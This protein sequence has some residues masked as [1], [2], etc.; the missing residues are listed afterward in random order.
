MGLTGALF[1]VKV[2]S[3][4][5]L[6]ALEPK[7][8]IDLLKQCC[9]STEWAT[10]VASKRPFKTEGQLLETAEAVWWGLRRE[11]W[12]EA[13]RAHPRLGETLASGRSQSA[14]WSSG[15]QSEVVRDGESR[16][17]LQRLNREYEA[18]FGWIF[19]L[20]ASGKSADDVRRSI[21]ERLKNDPASE[22]RVAAEEQNKITRL[23]IRKLLHADASVPGGSR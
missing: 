19:I 12:L 20:S 8:A 21:T 23:R 4:A 14:V 10:R 15:E 9:G 16:S 11:D 22:L 13:F 7:A 2:T 18:Q 17:E 1:A 6:N 5:A 3:L